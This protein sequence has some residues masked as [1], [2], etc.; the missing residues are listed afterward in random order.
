MKSVDERYAELLQ[1]SLAGDGASTVLAEA[2]TLGAELD[3]K[4]VP[5]A[6]MEEIHAGALRR[7]AELS[8]GVSLAEAAP[9]AAEVMLEIGR[10][11]ETARRR[12]RSDRA[13]EDDVP[14]SFADDDFLALL[15]H[16]LRTPLSPI[17]TWAELLQAEAMDPEQSASAIGAIERNAR[18]LQAMID[19]L[20]VASRSASGRLPHAPERVDLAPIV[21]E[22]V[23]G[24]REEADGKGVPLET[25]CDASLPVMGESRRLRQIVRNLVGN[26]VKFTSRGERVEV[27]ASVSGD[28]VR[29][30][31]GDRGRG[32]G[33]A[34]LSRIFDR[35]WP[36]SRSIT[37]RHRGLGLGL[38]V[39]RRLVEVHGGSI[40]AE[41]GGDGQ[42]AR[43][44]VEFPLAEPSVG[45]GID[46][47]REASPSDLTGVRVLVVDDEPDAIEA[48]SA[49]L[50]HWGA[51]VHTVTSAEE[52][53]S[54]VASFE[55]HV[56]LSDLAMPR[57]DGY[58]L[59]V[60]LRDGES[61][62][63]APRLPAIALTAHSQEKERRKAIQAG[64]DAVVAK[65]IESGELLETL[66][67]LVAGGGPG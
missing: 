32:L 36:V 47:P 52:A 62:R 40:V 53:L 45:E 59:V 34:E 60:A 6:A 7:L 14:S 64:F 30:V 33:P 26:A 39:V 43:F 28:R 13:D 21:A 51:K 67:V 46:A 10:A 58:A 56:L 23:E 9:H 49:L 37:R 17:L 42:G 1:R 3:E 31:V 20:S 24:F 54:A 35:V 50:R 41:S 12:R 27:E 5:R 65:P 29:L 48:A 38:A 16:E 66:G 11:Y 2:R 63:G 4:G 44:L 61:R 57:H 22:V 8:P 19:D 15:T 25:A 18:A 55:P